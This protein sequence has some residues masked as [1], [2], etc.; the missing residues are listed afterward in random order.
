VILACVT[1]GNIVDKELDRCNFLYRNV[2]EYS[3][4]W[5][6]LTW[7]RYMSLPIKKIL[8]IIKS[9]GSA[10]NVDNLNLNLAPGEL[11]EVRSEEE[12][13]S[14]LDEKGKLKGVSFMPEMKEFCGKKFK[15]YKRIEKIRVESSGE[16]RKIKNPTVFLEGVVCDGKISGP[17]D[18][19]CFCWWREAW[20]KRLP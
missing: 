5:R 12:I 8:S 2:L 6:T 9:K 3:D 15:V 19:A 10:L 14:T 17:C 4:E 13:L 16:I 7:R 1:G 20:L 18:R 11:V